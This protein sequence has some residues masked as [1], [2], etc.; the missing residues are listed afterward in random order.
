MEARVDPETY[1]LITRAAELTQESVSGFVV[2]A[3]RA[4]ADR[5]LARVDVT[6]LPAEQ[7]DALI[8]SLDEA[9]PAPTLAALH[10]HRRRAKIDH[11]GGDRPCGVGAVT[12]IAGQRS[13]RPPATD[14][15]LSPRL[16]VGA[17]RGA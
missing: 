5:V 14:R 7:F 9:D 10:P 8:D 17:N 1:E 2:R 13:G 4:E 15:G 3:A 16:S 6:A 12:G 11:E